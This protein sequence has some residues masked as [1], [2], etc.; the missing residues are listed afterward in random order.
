MRE[1]MI[2]HRLIKP[3]RRWCHP[4]R[5]LRILHDR[6]SLIKQNLIRPRPPIRVTHYLCDLPAPT[7]RTDSLFDVTDRNRP[8]INTIGGFVPAFDNLYVRPLRTRY[9]G[10]G[11][12]VPVVRT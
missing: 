2:E 1:P 7:R 12:T 10:E 6:Q 8:H 11:G 4:R 5:G 9:D 3:L